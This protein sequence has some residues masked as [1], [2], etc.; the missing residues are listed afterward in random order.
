VTV[1][2]SGKQHEEIVQGTRAEAREHEARMR[3]ELGARGTR[4]KQRIAP[5]FSVFCVE[6][7]EPH[8]RAHLGARTW[9]RERAYTVATLAEFFGPY[10]L[11]ALTPPLVNAFILAR[12]K[13]V[14]ATTLNHEL[15]TLAHVL[16]VAREAGHPVAAIKI[17][18]VRVTSR[19][20]RVWSEAELQRLIAQAKKDRPR[21][22]AMIVLM[23]NTGFRKGE[24]CAA[25]WSWVDERRRILSVSPSRRWTPK[26][27]RPREVPI[28]SALAAVLAGLPRS[29]PYIFPNARGERFVEFPQA[30]FT[31]VVKAAGLRG[32]PHTCRHS[33]ASMFLAA[34]GS[35]W[36]LST[37]LG[38]TVVK[39]TELYAHLLPGHLEE[40]R[41]RVNFS[42]A[43]VWRRRASG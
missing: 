20:V 38:H 23:V 3:I 29:S 11:D 10:R 30:E 18:R 12:Q 19:R 24:L 32:G 6:G 35:L 14:A 17:P 40:S 8:A 26:S 7:Y 16:T 36:Q 25:R 4:L 13:T 41:N 39:T 31:E 5:L 34:G 42:G 28:S 22:V 2:S 15:A 43:R 21:L 27:K 33:F 37:V 9:R 1:W